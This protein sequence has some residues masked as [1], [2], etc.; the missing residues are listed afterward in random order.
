MMD[1]AKPGRAMRRVGSMP[2]CAQSLYGSS[3]SPSRGSL[4]ATGS[5]YGL[6]IMAESKPLSS[7]FTSTTLSAVPQKTSP[8]A[9][10]R[11]GSSRSSGASRTTTPYSGGVGSAREDELGAGSPARPGMTA[12]PQHY[13]SMMS[14][15][16]M[17]DVSNPYIT[18]S[19]EIYERIDPRPDSLT[20]KKTANALISYSFLTPLFNPQV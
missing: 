13:G 14:R 9:L 4:R 15:T 2:T 16:F 3:V 6:P 19:Y 11:M 12:V 5:S 18:H 8:A 7:V 1:G 20:G 10:R 17:H